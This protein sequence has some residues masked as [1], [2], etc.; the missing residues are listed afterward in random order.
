MCSRR[1]LR[2]SDGKGH[3]DYVQKCCKTAY[4]HKPDVFIRA[5]CWSGL[6]VKLPVL[7][8]RGRTSSGLLVWASWPQATHTHIHTCMDVLIMGNLGHTDHHWLLQSLLVVVV[9]VPITPKYCH[10]VLPNPLIMSVNFSMPIIPYKRKVEGNKYIGFARTIY[11]YIYI[12]GVHAVVL[13]WKSP[14]L[15]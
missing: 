6:L 13:A 11:I 2:W 10:Q 15:L 9:V 5:V 3:C 4:S 8:K 1:E 7:F 14:N 12:Y